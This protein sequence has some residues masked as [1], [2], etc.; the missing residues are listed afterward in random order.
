MALQV[1]NVGAT[2]NDGLGDPIR[3][4]FI[5]CNDNFGELYSRAQTVPPVTLV[6]S[7]GDTAGMYAYDENFWYYCYA[8]YDGSSTIWAQVAQIG[9]ITVSGI[10]NGTS[11]AQ[12][13]DI[14]GNLVITINSVPDV[15]IFRND[16]MYAG[17]AFIDIVTAN[18]IF[19]T[20]STAAQ[21]NITTLGNL[22]NLTLVGLLSSN[23]N[24]STTGNVIGANIESSGLIITSG[25]VSGSNVVATNVVASSSITTPGSISATGNITTAGYF[26]GTFFGNITGNFV[27]P[28]T[29]TEVLFNTSGNADANA[30]FT[31]NK[32]TSVLQVTGN[33]ST[34]NVLSTVVSASGTISAVG[35]ITGGNLRTG[36]QVSA[37]GN[38]TSANF[39]SN[40]IVYAIGNVVG[41]NIRTTGQV[42]A[43]G[44]ITGGNISVGALSASATISASGNVTGGNLIGGGV[45]AVSNVVSTN[46]LASANISATGNVTASYFFGNGSLLTGVITSVSNITNGTST[47]DIAAANANIT[48]SVN[49]S[50]NVVVVAS[51]GQYVT[52]L[53]S[54][55]GN[56]TGGNL[57]ASGSGQ[58]S[59]N[60]NITGGNVLTASVTTNIGNG[61][62]ALVNG[63]GNGVGN[64]GES[65]GYFGNTFVTTVTASG[66]VAG[67][68]ITT[69][70]QVSA[71]GNITGGNLTVGTG[72]VTLGGIVNAN[73]N[74]VG[75]IGSSSLYFNT[76]FAKATSA[77]YA[78]LA[79]NYLA[80][81]WYTPGTVVVFGGVKEI[82]VSQQ[83]GDS[84]VAGVISAN[85]A[86]KMNSGLEGEHVA[87]LALIGRV[88]CYVTGPIKKGQLLVSAPNGRAQACTAPQVGTVVGKA[89]EDFEGGLGTIEI[90]VGKL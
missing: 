74:G 9:N 64:I 81:S 43:T 67:G 34:G 71:T 26:V 6:G 38:I 56:I 10:Q 48:T 31:F 12:F 28:G 47:V 79:E 73:A 82:T 90:A 77:Q 24:I 85:P 2:P 88:P 68:N 80:D 22:D 1:I 29:T 7:P 3:T 89:L 86:Y 44:N 37:A 11:D 72:T 39:L 52:G 46:M 19:G 40:G 59:T 83:I 69:T 36:G 57:L 13:D 58:I 70:N 14:D 60:G 41:G 63:G 23:A 27:V 54:V 5:K 30:N 35:N 51:T 87:T 49:G 8:N 15:A 76:V 78:D 17:N 61:G 21:T 4:S 75:N 65:S 55:S 18:T 16:G 20:L 33:V 32:S 50:S 84:A 45:S 42:S 66:N 53:S 62:S 25:N